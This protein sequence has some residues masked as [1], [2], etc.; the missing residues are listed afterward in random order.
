MSNRTHISTGRANGLALLIHDLVSSLLKG[1][2]RKQLE[3][4]QEE[5]DLIQRVKYEN[6]AGIHCIDGDTFRISPIQNENLILSEEESLFWLEKNAKLVEGRA[7]R[8]TSFSGASIPVVHGMRVARGQS[9]SESHEESRTIANGLLAI[10]NQRIIFH[11]DYQ[12]REFPLTAI[13]GLGWNDSEL[14]IHAS[15]RQKTM[16]FKHVNGRICL[17]IIRIILA[18]MNH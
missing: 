10:T 17:T 6:W 15:S 5:Y 2:R 4:K 12:N 3:K 8:I 13:S 16:C 1:R 11:G 9:V 14:Y 7:V 18:S